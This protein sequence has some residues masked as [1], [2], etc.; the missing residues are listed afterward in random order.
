MAGACRQNPRALANGA[1]TIMNIRFVS[2]TGRR[3]ITERQLQVQSKLTGR[4]D[5]VALWRARVAAIAVAPA[6]GI[7][8]GAV[9]LLSTLFG[10]SRACDWEAGRLR[11]VYPS[12]DELS[13]KTGLGIRSIQRLA[14]ELIDAGLV[15]AI[16]GGTG[17]R[18]GVRDADGYI[19]AVSSGIDLSPVSDRIDE[20]EAIVAEYRARQQEVKHLRVEITQE[21]NRVLALMDRGLEEC[22]EDEEWLRSGFQARELS[23]SRKGVREPGALASILGH[24]CALRRLSEARLAALIPVDKPSQGVISDT[25]HTATKESSI[26][27]AIALRRQCPAEK[28]R[29]CEKGACSNRERDGKAET[30]RSALR[31]F[32]AT[33]D[34]ILRIA[35]DFRDLVSSASPSWADLTGAAD[36]VRSHLGISQ[37]AWGQACIVLGRMEATSAIAAISAKHGAGLVRSPGGLLRHM[38]QAHLEGELRL[39]RTLFGLADAVGGLG[40]RRQTKPTVD[41]TQR[42]DYNGR[43]W[44]KPGHLGQGLCQAALFAGG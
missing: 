3:R 18:R 29:G 44:K 14:R 28:G 13:W 39:D 8:R 22:P 31:G 34:F 35:P 10:Y 20:L 41:F 38:V 12:N 4:L 17:A 19:R 21:R 16:D 6:L 37:H 15:K 43:E 9:D 33:P 5:A 30:A 32:P 2:P 24:L 40:P 1:S 25:P 36:M 26:A 27:K 23:E 7:G 11:V 42:V